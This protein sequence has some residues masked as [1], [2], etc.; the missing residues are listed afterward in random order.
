MSVNFYQLGA[1]RASEA[2]KAIAKAY[3]LVNKLDGIDE[4]EVLGEEDDIRLAKGSLEEAIESLSKVMGQYAFSQGLR[5]FS[6]NI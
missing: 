1:Q 5:E 4:S 3:Q 6:D 2:I